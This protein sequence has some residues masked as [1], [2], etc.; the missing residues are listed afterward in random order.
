MN[1]LPLRV[2]IILLRYFLGKCLAIFRQKNPS[3]LKTEAAGSSE[4]QVS[5]RLQKVTSQK[6][7]QQCLQTSQSTQ[8]LR[9]VVNATMAVV[10]R[11]ADILKRKT[12]AKMSTG[13]NRLQC[14]FLCWRL[15]QYITVRAISIRVDFKSVRIKVI[16]MFNCG[17]RS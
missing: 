14:D 8:Q 6:S 7:P 10:V 3:A 13:S 9:C 16:V 12:V 17:E 15:V 5:R 1:I 2:R 4:M 11:E